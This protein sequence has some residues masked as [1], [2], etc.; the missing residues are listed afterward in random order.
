MRDPNYFE[1]RSILHE[2]EKENIVHFSLG[3]LAEAWYYSKK[4]AKKKLQ[5]YEENNLIKYIP[6]NGRGNLS[7]I[8]FHNDFY[9]EVHE[10]L[11]NCIENKDIKF[12]LQLS[13]LSIPQE[14][15]TPFLEE[16]HALFNHS[17]ENGNNV[18]RFVIN[19]KIEVLD[20][21]LVSLHFEASL[22]KQI[23]NTLVDYNEEEDTF[24]SS[25]AIDWSHTEDFTKWTFNIRRNIFFHNEKKVTGSD[26]IFTFKEAAK[27]STGKWL[28]SNLEKAYSESENIV[29]FIF[30][31]PEP[32]FLKLVTHYSLVIRPANSNSKKLIGCGP[33]MLVES[34]NNYVYLKSFSK[35]FKEHPLI[36]G[37]E[38]WLIN[39]NFKKWLIVPQ[40]KYIQLN[41]DGIKPIEVA[42]SGAAYL[43]FNKNKQNPTDMLL[44]NYLKLIF[45]VADFVSELYQASIPKAYS[46]FYELS[47]SLEPVQNKQLVTPSDVSSYI[48][49]PLNLAVFNHP[50]LIQEALWFKERAA[51][52]KLKI[53]IITYTFD[54]DFFK[55]KIL[56]DADIALAMDVPVTDVE[57]GYL[58]FLLNKTLLF[59]RFINTE[60]TA[61]IVSLTEEYRAAVSFEQKTT[62]INQ[63]EDY[64]KRENILIYL[65]HPLKH[66]NIHTFINGVEF[67]SN[68]NIALGKLWW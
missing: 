22:I 20:P 15:F 28:L 63:I 67:D 61:T 68:G 1:L 7:T 39:S 56:V 24:T 21:N 57:L 37:V 46:Y 18:L 14:W 36:D 42:R 11:T 54:D 16:I 47:K 34:K 59:Q 48:D 45:N 53:E 50:R 43:I 33:F 51:M 35:Y 30:R 13:Q 19:R 10:V 55:E 9:S 2:N 31:Q 8:I 44:I 12:A 40:E 23:S 49:K 26:V 41:N 6:G 25:V 38:F 58:D 60:Q 17:S 5:K 62:L 4:N 65:Y 29:H 66:Y 27:S 64:I 52:F 32:S 3:K